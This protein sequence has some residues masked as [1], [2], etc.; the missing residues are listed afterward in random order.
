V[1]ETRMRISVADV[2]LVIIAVCMVV[3]VVWGE[4]AV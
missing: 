1:K 3:L 2:C 4:N